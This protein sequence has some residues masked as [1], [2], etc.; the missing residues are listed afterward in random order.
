ME[1]LA[2][3]V[4]SSTIG[5]APFE[6][7]F[8]NTSSGPYVRV[9]WDFGDGSSSTEINPV[10]VFTEDGNYVVTLRIYKA[11]GS[12]ATSSAPITVLAETADTTE[13]SESQQ[14]LFV[15]KRFL[16]GQ[17]AIKRVTTSS[18]SFES[19]A[20]H[21]PDDAPNDNLSPDAQPVLLNGNTITGGR[22]FEY[23]TS[24]AVDS[25]LTNATDL[26]LA[27]IMC[28]TGRTPGSVIGW[29]Q[30]F[31]GDGTS[32][33]VLF[34]KV[35]SSDT[36]NE[37]ITV[38]REIFNTSNQAGSNVGAYLLGVCGDTRSYSTETTTISDDKFGLIGTSGVDS[39][40]RLFF[41]GYDYNTLTA[42]RKTRGFASYVGFTGGSGAT[43]AIIHPD[44]SGAGV[45]NRWY[46][47]NTLLR[48][49]W[50]LWHENTSPGL[51]L[52]DSA[53]TTQRDPETGL[54]YRYLRD[55]VTTN[56][57]IVGQVFYDK[58]IALITDPEL[59]AA[60]MMIND[61]SWTLPPSSVK[62]V[63]ASGGWVSGASDVS[64]YITYRVVERDPSDGSWPTTELGGSYL[65]YGEALAG[66]PCQYIQRVD[67]PADSVGNFSVSIPKLLQATGGTNCV[68]NDVD[69]FVASWVE[70][71]MATGATNASGPDV[72]S[73][74]VMTGVPAEA[75]WTGNFLNTSTI[76]VDDSS[77][78]RYDLSGETYSWAGTNLSGSSDLQIGSEPLLFGY[79]SGNYA[80]DIYKTS[81][82]CV[83]KNNEFNNTQNITFDEGSNEYVYIT[84]VGL[85]NES[86]ELLMVGKL[87]RPIKKNSTKFVTVKL[88][89]DL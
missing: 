25:L 11:D 63:P 9:E 37:T 67:V 51:D 55:G 72:T 27:V 28:E 21:V 43:Y 19:D 3:F 15:T 54:R 17:V 87:S 4:P 46:P 34:Y 44:F 2:S 56:D 64:W 78:F 1:I 83:A 36:V 69:G 52:Y 29:D 66:L 80:T 60:L 89:L 84:E 42:S 30:A 16:P 70:L 31:P 57:T 45:V 73:W 68:A 53:D 32:V 71:Y 76:I 65:G 14:A 35:V 22:T 62:F 82:V 86:N 61:R 50:V 59:A 81:A 58:Q 24:A 41:D 26:T 8:T 6:V 39:A 79:M 18:S 75:A 88:E 38:D 48:L 10:K 33:P 85:Y 47:G 13:D 5:N 7:S 12:V 23:A 74:R 49:P 77:S 40:E 20:S